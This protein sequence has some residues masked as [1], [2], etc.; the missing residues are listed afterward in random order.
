MLRTRFLARL[1]CSAVLA[2]LA[3]SP[4]LAGEMC[5]APQ[6]TRAFKALSADPPF[7]C[8]AWVV[9]NYYSDATLTTQVGQCSITCAQ[10]DGTLD[11]PVFGGGGT[12]TGTSSAYKKELTTICRCQP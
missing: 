10:Y 3:V 4:A 8:N 6:Q 12:C 9:T 2:L 1:A 11:E 5:K 7:T